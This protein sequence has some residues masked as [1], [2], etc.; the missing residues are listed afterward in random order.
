VAKWVVLHLND[1]DASTYINV[2]AVTQVRQVSA[3]TTRVSFA[4]GTDVS[5]REDAP[6]VIA[7]FRRDA[8]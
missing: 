6:I 5:V 8:I 3:G 7:A 2:D 1:G 4:D